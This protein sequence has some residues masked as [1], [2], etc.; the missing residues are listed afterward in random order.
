MDEQKARAGMVLDVDSV[1]DGVLPAIEVEARLV[2][3]SDD[4]PLLLDLTMND[5]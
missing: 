5:E 1:A 3:D 2:D 4:A